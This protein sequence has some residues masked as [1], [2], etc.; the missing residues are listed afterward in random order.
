MLSRCPVL[1]VTRPVAPNGVPTGIQLVGRTYEGSGRFS[2]LS[3]AYE[4]ALGGWYRSAVPPRTSFLRPMMK[5][6]F[7]D[8]HALQSVEAEFYR[9]KWVEAFEIPRRA[10]LVLAEVTRSRLGPVIAPDGFDFNPYWRSMTRHRAVPADR[11]GSGPPKSAW[12]R[13]I[14]ISG[15]RAGRG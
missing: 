4:A 8:K 9:G 14:R 5:T 15:R 10:E 13:P 7:S 12:S 2:P 3:L 1:S 6:I 11:L